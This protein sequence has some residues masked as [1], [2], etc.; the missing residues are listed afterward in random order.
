[1][2]RRIGV[3]V[4]YLGSDRIGD[5]EEALGKLLMRNFLGQV[6]EQEV[7]VD[8][9]LLLNRGVFLALDGAETLKSLRALQ[10]RGAI[11]TAC[12]TCLN[13]YGV[14]DRLGVGAPG[15]MAETVEVLALAH[16][17]LRP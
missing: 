13:H 10:S 11:V 17:V 14:Q 1:M 7:K 3:N 5:G 2:E 12:T 9:V 6:A 8:R 4:L 16:R 15:T